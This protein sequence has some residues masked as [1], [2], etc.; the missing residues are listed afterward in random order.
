MN[1]TKYQLGAWDEMRRKDKEIHDKSIMLKILDEANSLRLAMCEG[2][3]PYIVPL[4]F[5]YADGCIYLHS[6]KKGRKLEILKENNKVAFQADTAVDLETDDSACEWGMKYMSVA[7]SGKA[8][9]VEDA[10]LKR[11]ALDVIMKKYSG[12]AGFEYSEA[13]LNNTVVI[14]IDI[15]EMTG[16]KS[17]Y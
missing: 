4:C 9:F 14:R 15:D 16:K 3:Q 7:G 10:D 12:R 1:N 11:N 6:A 13:V 5:G 17:G 2:N 8:S